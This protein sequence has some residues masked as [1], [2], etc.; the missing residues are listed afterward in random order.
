MIK[1]LGSFVR[2]AFWGS[3]IFAT[4]YY[5]FFFLLQV[6]QLK[7]LSHC[8]EQEVKTLKQI[9]RELEGKVQERVRGEVLEQLKKKHQVRQS[10]CSVG[11]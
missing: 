10:I 7:H 2:K 11:C 8:L 4:P 5:Y 3:H 6:K 1:G 9:N